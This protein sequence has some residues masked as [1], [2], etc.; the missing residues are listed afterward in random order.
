MKDNL[1]YNKIF[2]LIHLNDY[3]SHENKH[4]PLYEANY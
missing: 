2:F 4:T 3:F 1:L